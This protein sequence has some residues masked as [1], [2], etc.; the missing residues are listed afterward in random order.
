MPQMPKPGTIRIT[1]V[2]ID[3]IAINVIA[4]II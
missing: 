1:G 3:T 2:I 4:K